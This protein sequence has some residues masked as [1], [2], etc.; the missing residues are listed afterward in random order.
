M[1]NSQTAKKPDTQ[2]NGKAAD[3]AQEKAA[4]QAAQEA[5]ANGNPRAVEFHG[6]TYEILEGQPSPKAVTYIARYAVDD[7]NLAL[8]PAMIEMIGREQWADWCDRHKSEHIMEFFIELEK[9][10]G[11]GN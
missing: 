5:E 6:Y 10:A 3:E 8:V 7:E 11:S 4:A 9:A 1:S 2:A